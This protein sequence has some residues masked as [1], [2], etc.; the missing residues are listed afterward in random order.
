MAVRLTRNR[1][2]CWSSTMYRDMVGLL[3]VS[4]NSASPSGGAARSFGFR[5]MESTG[6]V[7]GHGLPVA[8]LSRDRQ[9]SDR[10]VSLGTTRA[11]SHSTVRCQLSKAA[12]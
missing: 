6:A 8:L 3:S 5:R 12:A 11:S 4:F 2:A 7:D 9:A 1:P 10:G